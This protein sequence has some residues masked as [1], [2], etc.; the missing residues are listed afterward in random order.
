MR[1]DSAFIFYKPLDQLTMGD[2]VSFIDSNP[3]ESQYLDYKDFDILEGNKLSKAISAFANS[4]GG[5]LI[6]GVKAPGDGNENSVPKLNPTSNDKYTK[7]HI[8]QK[9]SDGVHPHVQRI[10]VVQ[11]YNDD[12]TKWIFLVHIPPSDNP[13][14]MANDNRYYHRV[15]ATSIPMEH[16]HVVRAFNSIQYPILEPGADIERDKETIKLHFYLKN[17]SP[18]ICK[19]PFLKV[20]FYNCSYSV[21]K[22]DKLITQLSDGFQFSP[23]DTVIYGHSSIDVCDCEVLFNEPFFILMSVAGEN[24]DTKQ[25]CVYLDYSSP[26]CEVI[27]KK[28]LSDIENCWTE[29]SKILSNKMKNLFLDIF[30]GTIDRN[31]L[32]LNED[33]KNVLRTKISEILDEASKNV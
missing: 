28:D 17:D 21:D 8:T 30:S 29:F 25:F 22:K 16:Y 23:P 27:I 13:P 18:K 2:I 9:I 26:G 4:D 11:I 1:D 12:K 24:F 7:D 33:S 10:R 5:N 19:L 20:Q 6:I 15:E 3:K 31:A 14:H 32:T